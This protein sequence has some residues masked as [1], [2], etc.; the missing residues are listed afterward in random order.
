MTEEDILKGPPAETNFT[1]AF[2]KRLL[3]IQTLAYR[4]QYGINY[5]TFTPCNLYG[6]CDNFDLNSGHF[7]AALVRKIYEA[8]NNTNLEFWGSGQ[9]LRQQMYVEDLT[10]LI[11]VLLSEHNTGVPLIVAPT[12]E[13]TI[14]KMIKMLLKQVDKNLTYSF[15]DKMLGQHK[16]NVNNERLLKLIG[17]FPFRSFSVGVKKTYDWYCREAY[18]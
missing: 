8:K 13:H 18:K 17:D 10:E 9:A 6:P 1:Y 16:K 2:A 15:N 5:S 7:V 11:P 12:S 4:K 14:E 3:Y